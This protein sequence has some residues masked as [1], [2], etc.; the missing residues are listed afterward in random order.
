MA[1]VPPCNFSWATSPIRPSRLLQQ[2]P[3]FAIFC[4][5]VFRKRPF[6]PQPHGQRQ[7]YTN[8]Q[9]DEKEK[10]DKTE[11]FSAQVQGGLGSSLGSGF[12]G[13]FSGGLLFKPG[14][15]AAAGETAQDVVGKLDPPDPTPLLTGEQPGVH[16][17]GDGLHG[18][19]AGQTC[20]EELMRGRVERGAFA[21]AGGAKQTI[22]DEGTGQRSAVS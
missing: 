17:P 8:E 20:P 2:G 12:G 14:I 3:E 6:S 22:L 18:G 19:G 11:A 7:G 10:S 21:K 5:K 13:N 4:L 16:Q 9:A 15:T 1:S